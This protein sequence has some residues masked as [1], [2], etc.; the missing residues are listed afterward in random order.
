MNMEL[1]DA[2]KIV[3]AGN[4]KSRGLF[5]LWEVEQVLRDS[6]DTENLALFQK[7]FSPQEM[8]EADAIVK[9]QVEQRQMELIAIKEA[10]TEDEDF[11]KGMDNFW[12]GI[13]IV[14]DKDGDEVKA[15]ELRRQMEEI[16]AQEAEKEIL[17]GKYKPEDYNKLLQS[18]TQAN[19]IQ[20]VAVSSVSEMLANGKKL[21]GAAAKAKAGKIFSSL[22]SAE[23][24]E[25]VQISGKSAIGFMASKMNSLSKF[26]KRLADHTGLTAFAKQVKKVDDKLTKAYPKTYPFAKNLAKTGAISIL[27]GGVGIA[28][29]S[30]Y[31][32]GQ[33]V[34][35]QREAARKEKKSYWE[36][37][38]TNKEQLFVLGAGVVSSAVSLAGMSLDNMGLTSQL[39][40]ANAA[41]DVADASVATAT[42][43]GFSWSGA[44]EGI[45][46]NFT[47]SKY[48]LRTGAATAASIAIASKEYSKLYGLNPESQEYK[49]QRSKARKV[50]AGS[51]LGT[52]I[53]LTI[54]GAVGGMHGAEADVASAN[55]TDTSVK[56][57]SG[58]INNAL[59]GDEQSA[60][61][62]NKGA[63][64][65]FNN[66]FLNQNGVESAPD[67]YVELPQNETLIDNGVGDKSTPEEIVAND[68]TTYLFPSEYNS[69]M[70]ITRAQYNLLQHLYKTDDLDRMYLNLSQEGVMNNFEGM[71]KEEVLFKY[72]R[73]DAY[74]DRV[75]SNGNS[76]QGAI[77]Y[78]YE[79]EMT[80]I[81]KLLNCGDQPTAEQ[82]AA[83]NKALAVIDDRGGYHG[84]GYVPTSSVMISADA[85]DN[86]AEGHVNH[87]KLGSRI[88]KEVEVVENEEVRR[89]V[90]TMEPVVT[91][92]NL[93]YEAT[94]NPTEYQPE[95]ETSTRIIYHTYGKNDIGVGQNGITD[96]Y[97][98]RDGNVVNVN[99]ESE[100]Q[101]GD[102][103]VVKYVDGEEKVSAKKYAGFESTKTEVK[104]SPYNE[105]QIN[106]EAKELGVKP[107]ELTKVDGDYIKV[108]E[109]GVVRIDVD[110]NTG[111]ATVTLTDFDGKPMNAPTDVQQDVVNATVE[112]LN[113]INKDKE[114][115]TYQDVSKA[116]KTGSTEKSATSE[117]DTV[118]MVRQRLINQG[119]I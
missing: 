88:E 39:L 108:T 17:E 27:F 9:P 76:I 8:K 79:E 102:K 109:N 34:N 93:Q 6:G 16:S 57:N 112:E 1:Q 50:L 36:Y 63:K 111:K 116:N 46:N 3:K 90:P 48:L 94:F 87:W 25:K 5:E 71:T 105:E 37:L 103:L 59:S 110:A 99:S 106:A 42:S 54:S 11:K 62:W 72:Q 118:S 69:E 33:T 78:H 29:Y 114:V 12:N 38:K 30:T 98:E 75:D 86:C 52:L 56:N 61:D 92:E 31:R 26:A 84:P 107:N 18:I 40:D 104:Y 91:Y 4:L 119:K 19:C 28:V 35:Q 7:E 89:E 49:L 23:R 13:E 83:I 95:T 15:E 100:L 24:R 65:W 2:V 43:S 101:K 113:Q 117:V 45:K 80:A 66:S 77:R 21:S 115:V 20:L 81:N 68:T 96:M 14:N 58:N 60:W 22:F 70:G 64:P 10:Y 44:W 32:L 67:N 55:D 74:T 97:I 82:Y 47:N 73:L 41:K 51:A 85:G 53:G